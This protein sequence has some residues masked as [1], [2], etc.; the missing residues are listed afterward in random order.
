MRSRLRCADD[1]DAAVR[2][3]ARL[4][5]DGDVDVLPERGGVGGARAPFGA[6]PPTLLEEL[7]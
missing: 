6:R 4:G 1:P 3:I 7:T 5:P 2:A